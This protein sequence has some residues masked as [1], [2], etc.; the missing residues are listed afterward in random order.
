MKNLRILSIILALNVLITLI[1][2][3]SLG[4]N[5]TGAL[6]ADPLTQNACMKWCYL[7]V[8]SQWK[9]RNPGQPAVPAN[10]RNQT[11]QNCK[12]NCSN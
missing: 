11:K 3:L 2:Q 7:T 12:I 1:P 9:E 6:I 4:E 10:I 5:S 8:L